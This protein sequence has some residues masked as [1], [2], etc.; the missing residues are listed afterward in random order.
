M[1]D[2]KIGIYYFVHSVQLI[3]H[4]N[5]IKMNRNVHHKFILKSRDENGIHIILTNRETIHSIHN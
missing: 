3:L 4:N 2:H 5:W 1:R